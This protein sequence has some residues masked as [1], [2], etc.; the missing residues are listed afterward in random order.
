M[1][2]CRR[3]PGNELIRDRWHAILKNKVAQNLMVGASKSLAFIS[4]L[5]GLQTG[6]E[7][8]PEK[9]LNQG[10]QAGFSYRSAAEGGKQLIWEDADLL[11][12]TDIDVLYPKAAPTDT[13]GGPGQS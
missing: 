3:K 4:P 2:T 12:D 7:P 6:K 11:N 1:F 8:S 13:S 10:A 9:V 5:K